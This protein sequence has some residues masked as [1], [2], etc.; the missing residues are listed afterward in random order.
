M[1]KKV[2]GQKEALMN[3]CLSFLITSCDVGN[4]S[5]LNLLPPFP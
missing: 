3:S 1:A 5:L 2:L 4:I